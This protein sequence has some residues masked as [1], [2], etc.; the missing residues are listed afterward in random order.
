MACM[1]AFIALTELGLLQTLQ[2]AYPA[3][4]CNAFIV[5]MLA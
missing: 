5:I 1:S 2:L 4:L 3:E